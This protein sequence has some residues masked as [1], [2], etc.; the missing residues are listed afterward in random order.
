MPLS[1][2]EK[3]TSYA[4]DSIESD[5]R[6]LFWGALS[7]IS[8]TVGRGI[9]T[10]VRPGNDKRDRLHLN[11]FTLFI[12]E[13]GAGKSSAINEVSEFAEKAGIWIAPESMTGERL[14]TICSKRPNGV[15][16]V[17]LEELSSLINA[18]SSTEFKGFLCNSYDCKKR[19]IRGT[20][21]RKE[22]S[23]KDICMNLLAAC[24]PAY[25]AECFRALDWGQGLPARCLFIWG[26]SQSECF[27]PGRDK[28][29]EGELIEDLKELHSL[30]S[31]G[32]RILWSREAEDA[33]NGWR[34]DQA[35]IPP[36][37]QHIAGYWN[38]RWINAVKVAGI[39][40]LSRGSGVIELGDW[41][42]AVGKLAEAEAN[43]P[44]ILGLSGLN[45]LFPTRERII[46]FVKAIGRPVSEA[47]LRNKI[48]MDVPPQYV[49]SFIEDI[50]QSG[51][52]CV[53][54]D[55]KAGGRKIFLAKG[56][57]VLEMKAPQEAIIQ[58]QRAI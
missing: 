52:L 46:K 2:I 58:K 4:S 11:L 7:L 18:R 34:K 9:Y 32:L 44:L 26:D 40:A 47:E 51:V 39:L 36:A 19:Y 23:V 30:S 29:L 28:Q 48:A 13:P 57:K 27:L 49:E 16:T 35:K 3:F 15:L 20:Q 33:R 53:E 5:P 55:G 24:P 37:H 43:F 41:E 12:G 25:L 50:I 38:R 14:I 17:M 21:E 42:L 31:R 10:S 8:A 56:A 45:N 54:A 1:L 6:Y 22:E